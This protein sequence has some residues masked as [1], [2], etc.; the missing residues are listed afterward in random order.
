MQV[1]FQH[2]DRVAPPFV[3]VHTGI[4]EADLKS[5]VVITSWFSSFLEHARILDNSAEK[6]RMRV[7]RGE[8]EGCKGQ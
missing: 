2:T 5:Q 3:E 4:V 6:E 8:G 1:A 7:R